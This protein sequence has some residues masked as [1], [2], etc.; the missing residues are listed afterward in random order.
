MPKQGVIAAA[1]FDLYAAP[2]CDDPAHDGEL[3]DF[4]EA[5]IDEFV[6]AALGY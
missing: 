4:V 1:L 5:A 3:V 2:A 6:L